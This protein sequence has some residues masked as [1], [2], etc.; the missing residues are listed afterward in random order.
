MRPIDADSLKYRRKDYSGYDDVSD[1]ERS[2]GI[3]F[4]LKEDIAAAPTIDTV[5]R[6]KW[7]DDRWEYQPVCSVCRHPA[8]IIEVDGHLVGC[9]DPSGETG[10]YFETETEVFLPPYCPYCGAYMENPAEDI[11]NE[12]ECD[13]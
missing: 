8:E 11:L 7:I 1:E 9:N 2:R 10:G 12:D 3:L 4:L 13:E 6:G 5:K